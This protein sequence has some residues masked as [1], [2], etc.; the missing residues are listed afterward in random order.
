MSILQEERESLKEEVS[1]RQ[2]EIRALLEDLQEQR[3]TAEQQLESMA[4]KSEQALKSLSH[5]YERAEAQLS[6]EHQSALDCAN[7]ALASSEVS[8][9]TVNL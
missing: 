3:V 6:S 4:T 5:E 1:Q 7:K 9:Y 8:I 2:S